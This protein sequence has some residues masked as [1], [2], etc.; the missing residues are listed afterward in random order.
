MVPAGFA[1]MPG[2]YTP[3]PY[4]FGQPVMPPPTYPVWQ[5]P[6][7]PPYPAPRPVEP[8]R[9]VPTAT[10]KAVSAPATTTPKEVKA[11]HILV[12]SQ[13]EAQ[14]YRQQILSGQQRFE[15]IAKKV[16]KCPSGKNSGGDLGFF[17]PGQMVPEFD[18]VAFK[19]PVGVI[20]EPFKTEFGWHLM[21]VTEQR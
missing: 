13:Q 11:S 17:E 15:D 3:N 10:S 6:P 20:S 1:T 7:P 8:Q 19:L 9:V 5:A 2:Y 16:S 14:R 12:E 21:K 18:K 4:W